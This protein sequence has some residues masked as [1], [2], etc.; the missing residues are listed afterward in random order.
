MTKKTKSNGKTVKAGMAISDD[1]HK[2]ADYENCVARIEAA[3]GE[4]RAGIVRLVRE[5]AAFEASGIWR[6]RHQTFARCLHERF[7]LG[8][9]WYANVRDAIAK[10]GEEQVLRLGADVAKVVAKLT[11]ADQREQA[12]AALLAATPDGAE[13]RVSTARRLIGDIDPQFAHPHAALTEVDRLR[14][15]IRALEAENDRLRA[16]IN[17]MRRRSAPARAAARAS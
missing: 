7:R 14:D 8:A 2:L 10:L 13:P 4:A 16:K 1:V 11:R 5:L 3:L 12:V 17:G 9:E 6:I 15:R